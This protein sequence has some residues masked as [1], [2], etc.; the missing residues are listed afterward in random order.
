MEKRLDALKEQI[1][2]FS[3]KF[4]QSS[5]DKEIYIVSHFDTD[6]I[7]SAAIML[8]TLRKLDK[9]FSVRILKNLEK[10]FL[11]ALPK[12]KLII[13][14]DLA[15]GCL[16][17]FADSELDEVFIIDH[18]EIIQEIPKNIC[19][20]NPEI[21]GREKISSSGLTYLFC[22]ELVKDSK[23]FA[24]LAIL[25]M[26]GDLLEKEIDKLNNEIIF[27]GEILRKRGLLVYPSTR[28]LNR[29]LEY[30][31][32]P[33]LPEITGN[34]KGVLELLRE[35]GLSSANG[36]FKS[37]IELNEEEMEKLITGIMLR[38]PKA[39]HSEIIG[40]IFL[41]KFFNKLEDAREL[42]AMINACSRLGES[43]TALKF[44][45][46]IPKSKKRVEEMH[47]RYKQHLIS[48]LNYV[49]EAPKI[50]G[51]GFLII[52]AQDKI[53]DTMI[54]TIASI[55]S[56][57]SL[58]EDGTAIVTMAYY[59][60]KIKISARNVGKCGKNAREMLNSVV[61][62]IGGEVGGHEHAAG[63]M[64][65][66]EKENEFLDLLKKQLEIEVVKI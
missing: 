16:D 15:S 61:C 33:Y 59:D 44:C 17:F 40:D 13:F 24:K 35:T 49:Y 50:E 43:E 51:K 27:D 46:E 9:R 36:K 32:H 53:K 65:K 56:N 4:L 48:G 52:N 31:S 41:I 21:N 34:V 60:D 42:S 64:I 54:G 8:K 22:R 45:L 12:D 19:I 26:I 58:Y 1:K 38:N 63:A 25:G 28:P 6:G 66:K 30:S 20:I 29:A 47:A 3:Q 23:E 18:H 2:K 10:E 14:L 39:K 62:R 7:T 11:R 37:I 55:L 57:S 5:K